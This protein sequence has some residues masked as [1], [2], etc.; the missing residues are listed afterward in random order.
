MMAHSGKPEIYKSRIRETPT[1]STDAAS[2]SDTN[3]KKLRDLSSKKNFG[4]KKFGGSLFFLGGGA[5]FFPPFFSYLSEKK[6][7]PR[8]G[9]EIV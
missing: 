3:L 5:G 6:P 9:G 4:Q 8:H 1:L 2:R 7:S